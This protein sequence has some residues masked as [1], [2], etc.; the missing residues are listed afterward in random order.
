[1]HT[2]QQAGGGR[3]EQRKHNMITTRTLIR[4]IAG[5]LLSGGIP[6][7]GVTFLVPGATAHAGIDG[8]AV[9][10]QVSESE[11]GLDPPCVD[12][13][14]QDGPTSLVIGWKAGADWYPSY[15]I[16][17]RSATGDAGTAQTPWSGARGS[18]RIDGLYPANKYEISIQGCIDIP[19]PTCSG[20]DVSHYTMQGFNQQGPA[21][22]DRPVLQGP[23][24]RDARPQEVVPGVRPNPFGG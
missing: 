19:T 15:N 20:W 17:W 22:D 10:C 7:A 23:P 2:S 12:T 6:V 8:D 11:P 24:L 16:E 9:A 18:F 5:A 14:S 13:V 21:P 4:T 3:D 1:V